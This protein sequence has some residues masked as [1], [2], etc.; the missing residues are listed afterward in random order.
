VAAVLVVDDDD[1]TRELMRVLLRDH[2]VFEAAGAKA[3]LNQLTANVISVAVIDRHM[4]EFDGLWLMDQIRDQFPTIAMILATGD[5]EVPPRFTLQPGVIGYLMKPI[6]PESL[7]DAIKIGV[8][9]HAAATR[10][11]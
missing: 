8:S 6:K 11:R 5:D 7:M 9:W 10:R 3:A 1:S 4:P 2:S